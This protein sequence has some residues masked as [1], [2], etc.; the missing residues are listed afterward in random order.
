ME[1]IKLFAL[2]LVASTLLFGDFSEQN[3]EN[4]EVQE[5][6]K[7]YTKYKDQVQQEMEDYK[8]P[9][10]KEQSKPKITKDEYQDLEL[11]MSSKKENK[12][13][14]SVSKPDINEVTQLIDVNETIENSDSWQ[15]IQRWFILADQVSSKDENTIFYLIYDSEFDSKLADI[16]QLS[17]D[18]NFVPDD[19]LIS[20]LRNQ[21]LKY[22]DYLETIVID[23]GDLDSKFYQKLD[24]KVKAKGGLNIRENPLTGL[25]LSRTTNVASAKSIRVKYFISG[26][27]KNFNGNFVEKWAKVE[28]STKDG[29]ILGWA[30]MKYLKAK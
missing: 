3:S 19:Q 16:E 30:N 27:G 4:N 29:R 13:T 2:S 12:K 28:V 18:K 7:E 6:I 23:L 10:P 22:I 26:S 1:L 24:F 20:F 15:Y 21:Q 25:E 11:E 17:M 5:L 8:N 14:A 9:K